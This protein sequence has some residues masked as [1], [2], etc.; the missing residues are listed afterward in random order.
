M[1]GLV[2]LIWIGEMAAPTVPVTPGA[3]ISGALTVGTEVGT[4]VNTSV[5]LLLVPTALLALSK[6]VTVPLALGVPVIA[7]VL[8]FST[9]PAGNTL[10]PTTA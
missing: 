10:G 5:K 4:I 8:V 2:A 3:A 9:R 6:V 7:P 1:A